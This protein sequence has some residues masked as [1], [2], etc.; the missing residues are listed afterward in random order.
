LSRDFRIY[1]RPEDA[2]IV[3]NISVDVPFRFR[4]P[5]APDA[6]KL[7]SP[8]W[9]TTLTAEG[10]ASV[11]PPAAIKA[12]VS[13]GLAVLGCAVDA[14]GHLVDCAVNREEPAALDFG[15]A[16]IEAAKLM[17]MNPWTKEGDAVEGQRLNLPIRFTL[18]ADAPPPAA[19]PPAPAKP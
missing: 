12:G 14:G 2:K 3:R 16:A 4:D 1:V 7:V 9:T 13:S 6:R 18:Q 19:P 17:A 5:A 15:A 10:M 8:R 11:Y